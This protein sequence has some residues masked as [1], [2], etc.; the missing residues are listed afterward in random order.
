MIKI[1]I[2]ENIILI[3]IYAPSV[4]APKNIKQVLTDIKGEINENT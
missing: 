2:K 3:K 1:S 4:V